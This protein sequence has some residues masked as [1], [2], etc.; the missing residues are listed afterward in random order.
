MKLSLLH[1]NL[2]Y[3]I[4]SFIITFHHSLSHFIIRHYISSFVITFHH[5]SLHFIIHFII[6]YYMS[7]FIITCHHSLLHSLTPSLLCLPHHHSKNNQQ[8][9]QSLKWLR[10][11]PLFAWARE[12]TSTKM[13][14]IKI[15][16]YR[17]I[18]YT[19][20]RHVCVH[21]S[22]QKM[23]KLRQW[24]VNINNYQASCY[25]IFQQHQELNNNSY[26]NSL[27]CKLSTTML[28]PDP[29]RNYKLTML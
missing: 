24:R 5:S 12:R 14:S 16:Y 11:S 6:H 2:H 1:F 17:P 25:N 8:K 3:Y 20:C 22:A 15:S 13:H 26:T 7:S 29:I 27:C 4:S 10:L 9:C 28:H 19:V 21:F 18:K 23:Y